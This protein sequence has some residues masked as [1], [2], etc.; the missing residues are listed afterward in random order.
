MI[1][2]EKLS[3]VFVVVFPPKFHHIDDM[4]IGNF[5]LLV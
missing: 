1:K 5:I 2:Q 4:L 3:A